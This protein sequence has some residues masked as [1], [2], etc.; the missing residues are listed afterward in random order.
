MAILDELLQALLGLSLCGCLCISTIYKN[1]ND[2]YIPDNDVQLLKKNLTVKPVLS[3]H[4]IRRP[5][6]GS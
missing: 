6:L 5:K 3:G 4:S 2:V 1:Q